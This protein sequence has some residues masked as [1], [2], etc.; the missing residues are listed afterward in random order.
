MLERSTAT[1]QGGDQA[2]RYGP[3]SPLRAQRRAVQKMTY[4]PFRASFFHD[5][6]VNPVLKGEGWEPDRL[7]CVR[8]SRRLWTT[9]GPRISARLPKT[10]VA[11]GTAFRNECLS[12]DQLYSSSRNSLGYEAHREPFARS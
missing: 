3:G 10:A 1:I 9:N 5:P 12:A 2:S 7:S 11:P 4:P 6:A 8:D